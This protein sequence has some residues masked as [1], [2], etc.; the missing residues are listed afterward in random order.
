MREM[1]AA[2]AAGGNGAFSASDPAAAAATP[3]ES[4]KPAPVPV[5]SFDS[6]LK[7]HYSWKATAG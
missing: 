7:P 2:M 1:A 6:M 3:A 5:G 4:G